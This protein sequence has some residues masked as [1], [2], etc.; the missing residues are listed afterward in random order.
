[1]DFTCDRRSFMRPWEIRARSTSRVA[2]RFTPRTERVV[3]L[4]LGLVSLELHQ[5]MGTFEGTLLGD[6][7]ERFAVARMVGLAESFRAKW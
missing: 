3:R 4:P 6:D 2:L 7:G 1:M 5:H